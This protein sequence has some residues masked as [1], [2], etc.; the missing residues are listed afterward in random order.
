MVD[1]HKKVCDP[2]PKLVWIGVLRKV[3][4][5]NNHSLIFQ[6]DYS[7]REEFLTINI[8]KQFIQ[9]DQQ[10]YPAREGLSLC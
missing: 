4:N 9:Q 3:R 6:I 8:L 5:N 2:H 7:L 10:I 1:Q